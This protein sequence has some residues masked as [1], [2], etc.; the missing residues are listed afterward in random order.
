MGASTK[1]DK[2]ADIERRKK[3]LDQDFDTVKVIV[4]N[5][6]ENDLIAANINTLPDTLHEAY[7]LLGR[8]EYQKSSVDDN[9]KA[10]EK[11]EN[12]IIDV[13]EKIASMEKHEMSIYNRAASKDGAD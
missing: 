12:Y 2:G 13:K 7:D 6:N 1:V 10:H 9:G 5:A 4:N 8:L 3:R 11:Y